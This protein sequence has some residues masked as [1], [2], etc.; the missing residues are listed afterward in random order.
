MGKPGT[1]A[2]P[3]STDAL[4]VLVVASMLVGGLLLM[5]WGLWLV[6]AS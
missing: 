6:A 5:G 4:L 1:T 3:Q 2:A